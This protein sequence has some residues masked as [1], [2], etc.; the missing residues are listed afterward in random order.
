MANIK[1]TIEYEGTN[2]IGW[3]KQNKGNSIQG[4]IEKAI[5]LVTGENINLIGSGRTDSGVHAKGQVANFITKSKIPE[6]KF[7][8]ALNSKLPRDIAIVDSEKVNENFHA[9]YDALGKRYKY[10]I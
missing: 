10:L 4:E 9:R 8:F 2:Y 1:L 6:D 7:K 5:K 3:Q